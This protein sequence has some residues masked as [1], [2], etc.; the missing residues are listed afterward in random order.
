MCWT[1]LC[2]GHSYVVMCWTQLCV[3]HSYVLNTVMCWTQL[4]VEHSYVLNTVMC[5]TQLCV[6]HSY[7]L[8]TVMC[9]TQLCVWHS[10]VFDTV[11]CSKISC[12]SYKITWNHMWFWNTIMWNFCKGYTTPINHQTRTS[13]DVASNTLFLLITWKLYSLL[14]NTHRYRWKLT[15]SACAQYVRVFQPY[16]EGQPSLLRLHGKFPALLGQ[17]SAREYSEISSCRAGPTCSCRAH[18]T[19]INLF[20][21]LPSMTAVTDHIRHKSIYISASF[22]K[23][24][25]NRGLLGCQ[26]DILLHGVFYSCTCRREHCPNV[27]SLPFAL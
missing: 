17:I 25:F 15:V 9:W 24:F 11:M 7:V 26:N 21:P 12:D 18:V 16:Q 6:G 3:E 23:E 8:D 10:Y 4:C 20:M 19:G 14:H 2:I 1:Q 5:W 27:N 13:R 22:S